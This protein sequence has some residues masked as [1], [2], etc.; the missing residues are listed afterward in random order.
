MCQLLS[1]CH[2]ALTFYLLLCGAEAG[3]LQTNHTLPARGRGLALTTEAPGEEAVSLEP[4]DGRH[5]RPFLL[6]HGPSTS[7]FHTWQCE[8]V[9]PVAAGDSSMHFSRTHRHSLVLSQTP[10]TTGQCHFLSRVDT[11]TLSQLGQGQLDFS[12]YTGKIPPF[13]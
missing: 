10:A 5:W 11:G 6:P 9:T 3:H 2:S 1:C 12:H 13:F 4:G 8:C 7:V